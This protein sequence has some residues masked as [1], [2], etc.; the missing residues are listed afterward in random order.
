MNERKYIIKNAS[1]F[2][3]LGSVKFQADILIEDGIIKEIGN[4]E[5]IDCRIIDIKGNAIAPGFIDVHSHDD[6]ALI[7]IQKWILKLC[8]A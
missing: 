2:D 1:V 7:V 5:N 8:R 6:I 4:L 3:G